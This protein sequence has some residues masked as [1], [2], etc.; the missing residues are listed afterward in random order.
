MME[1]HQPLPHRS[2]TIGRKFPLTPEVTPIWTKRSRLTESSISRTPSSSSELPESSI[3]VS[4]ETLVTPT[5]YCPSVF[6]E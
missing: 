2:Q 3:S 4:T 6:E 1:E 5:I